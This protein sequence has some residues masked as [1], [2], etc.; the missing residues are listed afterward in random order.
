[1]DNERH[2]IENRRKVV[3]IATIGHVSSSKTSVLAAMMGL[4]G[5]MESSNV[6]TITNP[7][8]DMLD[9]PGMKPRMRLRPPAPERHKDEH[10]YRRIAKAEEKRQWRNAKRLRESKR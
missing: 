9:A 5:G 2:A 4:L 8:A 7:Y 3:N 10:D 6:F 1:M